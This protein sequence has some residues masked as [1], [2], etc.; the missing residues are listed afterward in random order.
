[1]LSIFM[2]R[3]SQ[4]IVADRKKLRGRKVGNYVR[5]IKYN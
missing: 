4:E 1:M 2:R 3:L 5:R